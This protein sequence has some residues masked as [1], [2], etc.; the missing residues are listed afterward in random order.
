MIVYSTVYSDADQ[1][2]RAG[3]SPGTGEFPAKWLAT[4]KMFPSWTVHH[5]GPY[6]ILYIFNDTYIYDAFTHI[7]QS[8]S[9]IHRC[10]CP[11]GN[12]VTPV[13][14]GVRSVYTRLCQDTSKHDTRRIVHV[15]PRVNCKNVI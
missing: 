4:R 9:A 3:N 8:C 5:Y 12:I 11:S 15:I 1:R 6:I 7:R 14:M 2:K 13:E 10:D